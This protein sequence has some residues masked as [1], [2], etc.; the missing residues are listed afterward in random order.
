MGRVHA[1]KYVNNFSTQRNQ[2]F[3]YFE[4]DEAKNVGHK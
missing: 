4:N 3:A 2:N 1:L